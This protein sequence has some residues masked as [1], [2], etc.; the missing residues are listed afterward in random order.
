MG[1]KR[2]SATKDDTVEECNDDKKILQHIVSFFKAHPEIF[3]HGIPTALAVYISLPLLATLW[4]WLP[5]IVAGYQ[6]YC[7]IPAGVLRMIW[8]GVQ[9]YAITT[10]TQT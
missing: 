4:A 8:E 1:K 3:T 5:W 2:V 9:K 10:K 7:L 6:I